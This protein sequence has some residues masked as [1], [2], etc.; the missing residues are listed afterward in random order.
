MAISPNFWKNRNVFIT[1]HTGF[2]GGWT[3]LWL[4]NLGANVFGY[5]LAPLTAPNFFSTIKLK[6]QLS[7]STFANI[8]NVKKLSKAMKASNPSII[9]HMAAQP[10]VRDSYLKPIDTFMCNVIGTANV[11]EATRQIKTVKAIVNVTTDKCYEINRHEHSYNENSRLGGYDPYSSSKACSELITSS[12]RRSF[13]ANLNVHLASVRAGNIIGGG[14]WAK[15]RLIPDFFK[16]LNKK[17]TLIVRSPNSIRPWQHVLEPISG[18]LM[19]AE[20]LVK[21]GNKYAEAWNFGPKENDTMKVSQIVKYLCKNIK[22]SSYKTQNI[23]QPH[24][25]KV[26]K[27][28]SLKA[29]TKL[30]WT[31]NWDLK[32]ALDKTIEWYQ[33]W[34]NQQNMRDISISQIKS[35]E[36]NMNK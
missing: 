31:N 2:V 23:T 11:L 7:Q 17:K 19:L 36:K 8:L 33:A 25:A 15:D 13:L 28:N 24:E 10:I 3:S 14:D 29:K 21:S 27:L 20:K 1:G 30:K 5:S 9:I 32:M 4:S 26:L 18:Y 6:K 22:G 12:Y 35:Y 16:A 34:A